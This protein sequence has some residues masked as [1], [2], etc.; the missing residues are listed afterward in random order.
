MG[1]ENR[2]IVGGYLQIAAIVL[3][4]LFLVPVMWFIGVSKK[5]KKNR[6]MNLDQKLFVEMFRRNTPKKTDGNQIP[7]RRQGV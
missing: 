6:E 4:G 2:E 3:L 7:V 1:F 5:F